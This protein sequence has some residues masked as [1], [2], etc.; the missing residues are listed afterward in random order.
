MSVFQFKQFSLV[1]KE[2]AAKLTT[3]ATIFGAWLPIENEMKSALEIGTGTGILSLMLAQRSK[4]NLQAIEIE[5]HAYREAQNNFLSSPWSDRLKAIHKDFKHYRSDN[6]YDLVFSNP[7][8]FTNSL[9]SDINSDKNTAYH[10]NQLSFKDISKGINQYLKDLGKAYVMLPEYEMGLFS[11]LLRQNGFH[12]HYTLF[13]HHNIYKP[14]LRV[15]HGFSREKISS[16]R[17]DKIFIR[18]ENND[19]HPEY[20]KLLKPFLTI[21]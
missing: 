5:E 13:I 17:E 20:V 15:I 6:K 4:L 14:A 8:F 16:S 3:D 11:D 12:I 19:F 10:T 7:P 1:Q 2:S 18:D 21:F 9:Q